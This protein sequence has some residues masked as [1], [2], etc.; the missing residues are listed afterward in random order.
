MDYDKRNGF[1]P[2]PEN[3]DE[4]QSTKNSQRANPRKHLIV[5]KNPRGRGK[6]FIMAFETTHGNT[7]CIN[8]RTNQVYSAKYGSRD[9]D[10]LFSVILATGET[11]Q[12]PLTLFYDTPEQYERHFYLT[13][14]PE[15]KQ[16][17]QK[18][19]VSYEISKLS[20]P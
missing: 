20:T 14:S 19:R 10:G 16:R 5:R 2:V 4:S 11:G 13:L 7:H 12:T 15:T 9:E 8:A 17:W 3:D 1:L 6:I 18:K